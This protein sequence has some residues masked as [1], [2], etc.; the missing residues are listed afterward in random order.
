MSPQL[1]RSYPPTILELITLVKRNPAK[2]RDRAWNSIGALTIRYDDQ[3]MHL[4]VEYCIDHCSHD[5][6]TGAFDPRRKMVVYSAPEAAVVKRMNKKLD[7]LKKYAQAP[8]SR[9]R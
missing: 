9:E 5:R 7:D 1:Y 3:K 8:P 2:P 4:M 6:V